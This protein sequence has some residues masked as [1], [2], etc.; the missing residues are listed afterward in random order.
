MEKREEYWVL[1]GFWLGREKTVKRKINALI[2]FTS[3][4]FCKYLYFDH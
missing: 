4:E 2:R 3:P 1:G